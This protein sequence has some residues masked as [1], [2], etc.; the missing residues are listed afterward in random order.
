MLQMTYQ[1]NEYQFI[2][3]R[4]HG[5]HMVKFKCPRDPYY[6]FLLGFIMECPF[7]C[8]QEREVLHLRIVVEKEEIYLCKIGFVD[9]K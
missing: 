6:N 3:N 7:H 9:C 1:R 4:Y 5:F 8:M 2:K